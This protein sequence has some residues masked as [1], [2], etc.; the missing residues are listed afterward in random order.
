MLDSSISKANRAW[1][2]AQNAWAETLAAWRDAK[3]AEFERTF[4]GEFADSV[5][6][7]LSALAELNQAIAESQKRI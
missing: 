7:F 3:A 2:Q 5:P 1:A 6:K 4:W